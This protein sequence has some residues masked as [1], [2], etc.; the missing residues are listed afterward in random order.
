M[1]QLFGSWYHLSLVGYGDKIMARPDSDT[2]MSGNSDTL[3]DWSM[4][5]DS[6]QSGDNSR[7]ATTKTTLLDKAAYFTG[8]NT[9]L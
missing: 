9:E 4:T 8:V 3:L 6:T 1:K 7:S 2:L 5:T